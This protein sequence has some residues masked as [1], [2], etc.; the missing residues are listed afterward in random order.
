MASSSLGIYLAIGE[1]CTEV[2]VEGLAVPGRAVPGRSWEVVVTAYS[3]SAVNA[4]PIQDVNVHPSASPA[5][6]FA[7]RQFH[8]I[9]TA[10]SW[11][12]LSNLPQQLWH[13]I[14]IPFTSCLIQLLD[15]MGRLGLFALLAFISSVSL[16]V[17]LPAYAHFWDR[18]YP[19]WFA[20]LISHR[21]AWSHISWI[22]LRAKKREMQLIYEVGIR[23]TPRSRF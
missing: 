17:G 19:K 22:Y 1:A 11:C 20:I 15:I 4:R 12:M 9:R 3:A 2:A 7:L 13:I 21:S 23:I 10:S 16:K 18:R 5:L 8:S 6:P 14:P